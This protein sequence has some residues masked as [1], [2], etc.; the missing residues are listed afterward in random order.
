MESGSE[1]LNCR[2]EKSFF[3][4]HVDMG[5]VGI[6]PFDAGIPAGHMDQRVLAGTQANI[7][8][9]QHFSRLDRHFLS[10]IGH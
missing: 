1:H 10:S 2:H 4:G 3:Q 9:A 8:S 5:W 7:P 6:Y